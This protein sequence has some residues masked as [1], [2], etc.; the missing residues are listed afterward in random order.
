[1][2]EPGSWALPSGNGGCRPSWTKRM[3]AWQ[4]HWPDS[5]SCCKVLSTSLEPRFPHLQMVLKM[6]KCLLPSQGP[7]NGRGRSGRGGLHETHGIRRDSDHRVRRAPC[8]DCPP[9][10]AAMHRWVVEAPAPLK[11][12]GTLS[13][14]RTLTH[15]CL[16]AGLAGD[17]RPPAP[18][19]PAVLPPPCL[20][21]SSARRP[22]GWTTL[23]TSPAR[24]PG[25]NAAPTGSY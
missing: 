13:H 22:G 1:M 21:R 5:R 9:P 15:P 3:R 10:T 14:R 4:V 17:S 8:P 18:Q 11:P 6:F 2:G 7:E 24:F 16:R 23:P 12:A 20:P 19:H 25:G